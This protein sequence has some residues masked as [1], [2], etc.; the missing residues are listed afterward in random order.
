MSKATHR[1]FRRPLARA[2]AIAAGLVLATG[3]LPAHAAPRKRPVRPPIDRGPFVAA[4]TAWQ[5][6]LRGDGA[7]QGNFRFRVDA[8]G[9]HAAGSMSGSVPGG[10]FSCA[11]K[12]PMH[13]NE[14]RLQCRGMGMQGTLTVALTRDRG[15]GRFEG[16]LNGKPIAMLA[17]GRRARTRP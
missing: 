15:E 11:L 17:E 7:A 10:L 12:G 9:G 1:S 16:K 8:I 13:G 14:A 5:G 3:L 6:A 2:A 4:G